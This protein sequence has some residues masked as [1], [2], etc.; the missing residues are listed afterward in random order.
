MLNEMKVCTISKYPPYM[1]GHSFEAL[2]QGKALLE[3]T[4]EK[5]YEVTYDQSLYEKNTNY[6][7]S[8]ELMSEA[9]QYVHVYR[10]LPDYRG[11]VKVL[12]GALIKAFIGQVIN[13]IS[14][15]Q[16][17]V[18]STFYLDPHA[19]I[20]N[21]VKAYAQTVLDR[22]IIT[23][24]KAVG[25]DVLNS[26]ANHRTDGEGKFLLLQLL[27]GDIMLAVSQFT[28][29]KIVEY[30]QDILPV[31]LSERIATEMRVLYA[32]FNNT[33]FMERDEEQLEA[34]KKK[35][36]LP[37]R[38]TIISYFGRL[39]PE[40]GVEDL[41]AAFRLIKYNH[42]ETVLVI[43]GQGISSDSLKRYVEL[44]ALPDVIFTGMISNSEKRALMQ[45]S[46]VGVI[47]TKPILNFV[48]TLCVSALEYQA[49]GVPLVT[50]CVGGV[51]EAAGEH[52]LYAKH[53][54]PDDLAEKI[55]LVLD[56]KVDCQAMIDSGIKHV[57]QF[58]YYNITKMFMNYLEEYAARD[59]L[60]RVMQ[61]T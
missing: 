58:N 16:I 55:A 32:P 8:P 40:K 17:N 54:S 51:T 12:D 47:P 24:H 28:K 38:T 34:F 36:K 49:A 26:I 44:H 29:E 60:P 18:L 5:H 31:R 59:N 15:K 57:K 56:Q 39:F 52:S 48:E 19:Y 3:M 53:S 61:T 30:A 10:V 43:G 4:G 45:L 13:L 35:F 7:N 27:S 21:Q 46:S 33:Y 11:N 2:Y 50:T 20:A 6:N 25:S 9:E 41:L 23:I 1:S 22:K 42:P 14:E 37:E